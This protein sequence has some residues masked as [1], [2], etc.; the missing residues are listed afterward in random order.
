MHTIYIGYSPNL[1][2]DEVIQYFDVDP[3]HDESFS[4][5]EQEF[6]SNYI[7]PGDF[8]VYSPQDYKDFEFNESFFQ[9]LLP[10]KID[11][12][13]IKKIDFMV[14]KSLFFVKSIEIEILENDDLKLYGPIKIR[15]FEYENID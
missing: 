14:A 9:K 2:S 1:S 4:K 13:E 5:F 15:R 10:F 12:L 11:I 7:A 3:N 6:G 8:E